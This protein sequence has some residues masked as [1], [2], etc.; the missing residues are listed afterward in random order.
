MH[1]AHLDARVRIAD[2]DGRGQVR[3][4]ADEPGV[5]EAVGGTGLAARRAAVV[6]GRPGAGL[7]VHL[8][9]LG[10]LIGLAVGQHAVALDVAQVV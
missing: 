3:L 6:G 4:E 1:A 7:H 2:P 5:G 10:D 9:D 8:Q